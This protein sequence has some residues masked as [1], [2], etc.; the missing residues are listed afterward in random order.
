MLRVN[1]HN[2]LHSSIC[3]QKFKGC[4]CMSNSCCPSHAD[5][6]DAA[7]CAGRRDDLWSWL[8]VIVEMLDG[9]LCWRLD[10]DKQQGDDKQKK[11]ELALL[12]KQAAFQNPMLL[13][14]Q[15]ELPGEGC[16]RCHF[17]GSKQACVACYSL[18]YEFL[19][20]LLHM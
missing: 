4:H 20:L 3:C 12:K 17:A 11:K 1:D 14:A 15:V 19:S 8:Y 2:F 7:C 10:R 13:T 9:G 18:E 16:R 5:C 6:S